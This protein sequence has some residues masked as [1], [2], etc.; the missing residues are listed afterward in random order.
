VAVPAASTWNANAA[1]C[2][3]DV[4]SSACSNKPP[5][6]RKC[7]NNLKNASV[8]RS[9]CKNRSRFLKW[10]PRDRQ[11]T[12][13]FSG[14]HL[15]REMDEFEAGESER[16][17]EFWVNSSVSPTAGE[18]SRSHKHHP[19]QQ[20]QAEPPTQNRTPCHLLRNKIW[21]TSLV[22]I[23]RTSICNANRTTRKTKPRTGEHRLTELL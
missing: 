2:K 22:C 21:A 18:F 8:S 10:T 16:A 5:R 1:N 20:Q 7:H 23:S 11:W 12:F 3:R 4:T 15:L 14:V 19:S 13:N 17:E 9:R 6:A